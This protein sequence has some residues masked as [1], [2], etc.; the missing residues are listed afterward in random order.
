MK[1]NDY[2]ENNDEDHSDDDDKNKQTN[3]NNNFLFFIM[4]LFRIVVNLWRF[5][6]TT[7]IQFKHIKKV[8]GR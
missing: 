6:P 4:K 3:K 1:K 8:I 7:Q 5:V 2:D